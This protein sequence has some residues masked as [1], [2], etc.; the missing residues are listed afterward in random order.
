MAEDNSVNQVLAARILDRLGYPHEIVSN[1]REAVEA[2]RTGDYSLILMDCMMPEMD[3]FAA[4][5]AI[6]S[7][8]T[9]P[10]KHTPI[11]AMTAD[12]MIGTRER[13]MRAGMDDYRQT[14]SARPLIAPCSVDPPGTQIRSSSKKAPSPQAR[15]YPDPATQPA[16][17]TDRDGV[18]ADDDV[19]ELDAISLD[20]TLPVPAPRCHP[21]RDAERT[22]G[23]AR[24]RRVRLPRRR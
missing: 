22:A 13:C 24:P 6:R 1:G 12:A 21:P 18:E 20:D 10:Q 5:Q 3:G 7:E 9:D 15:V 2:W 14:R 23:G 11:I 8:E 19:R 17:A 4:A 16:P